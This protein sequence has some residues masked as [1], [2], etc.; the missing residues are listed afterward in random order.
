MNATGPIEIA[1]YLGIGAVL[2]A[3]YFVLLHHSV[4]RY[5]A[6]APPLRVVSVFLL[7]F[8]AAGVAFWLLA[9]QG[10]AP[11]LLAML[12]FLAARL[13]AQRRMLSR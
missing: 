11:L 2:G 5:V 13:V 9:Q 3:V 6:G 4:R 12:G 1:L 8:A 10:A 7:R